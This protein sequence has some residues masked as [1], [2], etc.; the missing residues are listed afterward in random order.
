MN[1]LTTLQKKNEK[2][3]YV[4]CFKIGN[5]SKK[6]HTSVEWNKNH[7]SQIA[8]AVKYVLILVQ[9]ILIIIKN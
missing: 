4:A 8:V 1:F 6:V 2:K 7:Q 9:D 5:T 3:T